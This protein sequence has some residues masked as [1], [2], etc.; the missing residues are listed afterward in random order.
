MHKGSFNSRM[1]WCAHNISLSAWLIKALTFTSKK[2][3]EGQHTFSMV[4][5]IFISVVIEVSL[6]WAFFKRWFH[7]HSA[8][9]HRHL[10]NLLF[11]FSYTYMFSKTLPSASVSPGN[12]FDSL[13]YNCAH[14]EKYK[15]IFSSLIFSASKL[16]SSWL[17]LCKLVQKPLLP[18]RGY[19]NSSYPPL[20][21]F[22]LCF[23]FFAIR[24]SRKLSRTH[25]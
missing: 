21:S 22:P 20:L 24:M 3:G 8:A 6:R 15:I 1:P 11:R 13:P 12:T 25:G 9:L 16:V 10:D 19:C 2:K 14:F 5:A 18:S 17:A 7:F 4:E 23:S